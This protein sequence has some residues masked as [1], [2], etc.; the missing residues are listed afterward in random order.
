[1]SLRRLLG[2]VKC[3][4]ELI[5]PLRFQLRN[6]NCLENWGGYSIILLRY[7]LEKIDI[8]K[9]C[10]EEYLFNAFSLACLES[11]DPPVFYTIQLPVVRNKCPIRQPFIEPTLENAKLESVGVGLH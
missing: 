9:I 1:M 3:F 7:H 10:L 8:L 5:H 2:I 11:T 4:C 6:F